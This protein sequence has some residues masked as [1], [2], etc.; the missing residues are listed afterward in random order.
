M[1]TILHEPESSIRL[2]HK[3]RYPTGIFAAAN[4]FKTGYHNAWIRDNIYIAMA[5]ERRVSPSE[6]PAMPSL[7]SA[8]TDNEIV[9]ETYQTL[10]GLFKKYEWKIDSI[11]KKQPVDKEDHLHSRFNPWSLSEINEEW[12]HMQNDAIGLFLFKVA[13]LVQN[14]I[15]VLKDENDFRILQK[16]VD[17]LG[18][19]EYWRHKDNGIWENDE[20]IHASSVGACVAGLKKLKET[21]FKV[22]GKTRRLNVPERLI[23]KG[24]LVLN[25]LL[26]RESPKKEVDLALLSLI[27]PFNI[28]NEKQRDAILK[29]VEKNLVRSKGVIRYFNDDYYFKNGEAEWTMGFPWL[30]I[31]YKQIGNEHKYKYYAEKTFNVMNDRGEMPELYFAGS[32]EH[33]ENS[34]LGWAQALCLIMMR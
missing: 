2:L 11:I 25:V 20:E 29:N 22:L 24:K 27:W 17:Y 16:L 32:D 18:A 1:K 21:E 6:L 9:I 8:S 33:N 13:D 12:G 30:A 15:N 4:N 5:F 28:V 19:I 3:L 14:G 26:P 34:P 23:R 10:L 31:I 7:R